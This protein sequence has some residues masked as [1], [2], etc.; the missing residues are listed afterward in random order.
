MGCIR[1]P[2]LPDLAGMVAH[3][4]GYSRHNRPSYRLEIPVRSQYLEFMCQQVRVRLGK[5]AILRAQR[6][7][8][9]TVR[10]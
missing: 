3:R 1:E 5:P 9:S 6:P 8:G 4:A 7:T 10:M 2:P